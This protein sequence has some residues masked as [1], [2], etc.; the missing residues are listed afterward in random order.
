VYEADVVAR[1]C[2]VAEEDFGDVDAHDACAGRCEDS[3]VVSFPAAEIDPDQPND[4]GQQREECGRVDEVAV[5][6]VAG[7]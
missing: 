1:G 6:V 3:S 2:G 5:D 4:R 7:S